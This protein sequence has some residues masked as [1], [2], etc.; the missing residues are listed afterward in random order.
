M[1]KIL[2]LIGWRIENSSIEGL[3]TCVSAARLAQS[4]RGL[5]FV[6]VYREQGDNE[7]YEALHPV[8]AIARQHAAIAHNNTYGKGEHTYPYEY[9]LDHVVGEYLSVGGT[10]IHQMVALYFHDVVEDTEYDLTAIERFCIDNDLNAHAVKSTV[11]T[12]TDVPHPTKPNKGIYNANALLSDELG[13]QGKLCD[14]LANC[15]QGIREQGKPRDKYIKQQSDWLLNLYRHR[16]TGTR[17]ER[18]FELQS[19]L[20]ELLNG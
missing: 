6:P 10:S 15:R 4:V 1:K 7:Y 12:M 17:G 8:V 19:R 18:T 3:Y 9:H 2:D 14:R 5:V 16:T 13:W 20:M 11:K